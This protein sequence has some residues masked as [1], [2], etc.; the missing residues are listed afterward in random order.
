MTNIIEF[1]FDQSRNRPRPA[2]PVPA[3]GE[4]V[5]F[6]GVRISYWD[7]VLGATDDV[8]PKPEQSSKKSKGGKR[9]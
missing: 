1:R 3:T 6:P 9:R 2:G 5:I 7:D 4:I 8:P